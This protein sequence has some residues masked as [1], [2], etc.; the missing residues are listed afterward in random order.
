RKHK[1]LST[2]VLAA[3]SLAASVGFAQTIE[4]K[5]ALLKAKSYL[6]HSGFSHAG[7]IKQL[8]YEK[9]DQEDAEYA[10]DNVGADWKEQAVRKAK[11]YLEHSGFSHA[12]LIKQL[13]YEGFTSEEAAYAADNVGADWKEQAVKKAKSYLEHSGYSRD[14]LIK[15]LKY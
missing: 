12:G 10:A 9:F 4:Q 1:L 14:G 7:L 11:S 13:K 3:F 8:K 2:F 6:E 5:N 15:Q